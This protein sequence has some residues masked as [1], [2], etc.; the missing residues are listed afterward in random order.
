MTSVARSMPRQS[1]LICRRSASSESTTAISPTR[2][3]SP[4]STCAIKARSMGAR[5]LNPRGA[6]T[7]T[8]MAGLSQA[9]RTARNAQNG[10]TRV[11]GRPS[12]GEPR[13]SP[14]TVSPRPRA[15]CGRVPTSVDPSARSAPRGIDP[16]GRAGEDHPRAGIMKEGRTMTSRIPHR[17]LGLAVL[18]GTLAAAWLVAS[19]R[20]AAAEAFAQKRDG[21]FVGFGVGGGT[22]ALTHGGESTDREGAPAGSFRAGFDFSPELGLGL[23]TN[24]W[25]KSE[26]VSGGGTA[27]T[28]LS[29]G[30]ATLYYHPPT[31]GLVL[32]GGVGYGTANA[33]VQFGS[34]SVSGSESGFGFT[35]GAQYD[36]RVRRT[37]SLGPTVDFG[38]MTLSDFDAN[39]VNFGLS[40]DWHFLGR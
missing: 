28:T 1:W 7:V 13:W 14:R 32:R 3:P 4:R 29:V 37:F 27:T 6:V 34:T 15:A 17:A 33:K 8:G 38:W 16:R 18:A 2:R 9:A 23:E 12:A 5:R 10:A 21:W 26:N 25:S 35:V 20:P 31:T 30:A 36:F 39:Y 19:A 22:A 11:R 24:G 40:F